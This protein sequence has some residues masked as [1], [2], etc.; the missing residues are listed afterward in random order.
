[1]Y[2]LTLTL[3]LQGVHSQFIRFFCNPFLNLSLISQFPISTH[4]CPNRD[5][6]QVEQEIEIDFAKIRGDS[7]KTQ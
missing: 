3:F 4:F 6:T 7:Y 1:M 5:F 2:V